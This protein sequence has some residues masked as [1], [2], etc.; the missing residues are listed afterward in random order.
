[1]H[2]NLHNVQIQIQCGENV[3]FRTDRI[4]MLAAHHH[5]CIVHQIDTEDERAQRRV[6]QRNRFSRYEN[7]HNAENQ[8]NQHSDKQNAA[9][10]RK[11]P[12]RLERKQR[13]SQANGRRYADGHHH[14]D[15]AETRR[16]HAQNERLGGREQCQK[17]E[18]HRRLAANALTAGHRNHGDE[19]DAQRDPQQFR[20]FARPQSRALVE[21]EQTHDAER[22]E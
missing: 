20:V 19:Q 9:H 18:V 8:Q 6:N 12:F 10:H 7:R 15:L 2:E 21:R 17:D 4:L 11:V 3:L 22:D 16:R 5:L 14:L 1:M 13:Q